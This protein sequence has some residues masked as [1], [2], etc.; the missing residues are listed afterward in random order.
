MSHSRSRS[1]LVAAVSVVGL[2]FG[3]ASVSNATV[4]Y[5]G[6]FSGNDCGGPG[7]FANCYATTTGTHQGA[8]GGGSPTIYKFNNGGSEDFGN[9]ASITGDEF[10]ISYNGNTNVLSWT[11]TPGAN[12]PEIHY[13]DTKQANGFAL[14]YDLTSPITSFS[15]DLDDYFLDNP[16]FSHVT[17]FD[18]GSTT[19]PNDVPEPGTLAVFGLGLLGLGLAARRRKA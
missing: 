12:D 15:V 8:T 16:G 11:Y 19:P 3:F 4:V 7:G 18:T 10:V 14:F 9:F 1:F 2:T 5:A 6:N 17:F 13:F